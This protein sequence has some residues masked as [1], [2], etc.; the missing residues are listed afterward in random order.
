MFDFKIDK[1][2]NYCRFLLFIDCST[3]LNSAHPI[4][5]LNFS[6]GVTHAARIFAKIINFAISVGH[7]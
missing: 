4:V 3:A 2:T 5:C 7:H 6:A 1:F